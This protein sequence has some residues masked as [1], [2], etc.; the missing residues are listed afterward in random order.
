[1]DTLVNLKDYDTNI[2]SNPGTQKIG[3]IN[4]NPSRK[5]LIRSEQY[6]Q[7]EDGKEVNSEINYGI[8]GHDA[9]E[10]FNINR[11]EADSHMND[12]RNGVNSGKS[13]PKQNT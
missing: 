3:N 6:S 12:F 5:E 13:L 8:I 2:L 4:S 1:M 7:I 11:I 9:I 10:K